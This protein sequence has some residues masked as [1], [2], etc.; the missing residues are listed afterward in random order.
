MN[1]WKHI[2][3]TSR[4]IESVQR[5]L[6]VVSSVSHSETP[7]VDYAIIIVR[8]PYTFGRRKREVGLEKKWGIKRPKNRPFAALWCAKPRLVVQVFNSLLGQVNA[9]I[10]PQFKGANN[11]HCV[12]YGPSSIGKSYGLISSVA[13]LG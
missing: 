5:V 12:P 9:R 3:Y 1:I 7:T 4:R 2:I 13:K 11:C 8:I 6:D 10:Q